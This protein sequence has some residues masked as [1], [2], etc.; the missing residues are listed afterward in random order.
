MVEVVSQFTIYF[1]MVEKDRPEH[2]SEKAKT[3]PETHGTK[4]KKKSVF[5]RD[6]KAPQVLVV[7][8]GS[9]GTLSLFAA[10]VAFKDVR[11]R[12]ELATGFIFIALTAFVLTAYLTW[13]PVLK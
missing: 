4:P 8:A 3:E 11:H 10:S 6:T 12:Y 2:P 5:T 9:V 13:R 7:A 1:L